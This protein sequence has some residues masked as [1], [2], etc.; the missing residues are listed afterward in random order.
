MVL[1]CNAENSPEFTVPA[2]D[3]KSPDQESWEQAKSKVQHIQ[4]PRHSQTTAA[5]QFSCVFPAVLMLGL[6]SMVYPNNSNTANHRIPH[7]NSCVKPKQAAPSLPEDVPIS[8]KD[9]QNL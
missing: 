8:H 2:C 7:S 1:L 9:S 3:R 5:A 6:L 4:A